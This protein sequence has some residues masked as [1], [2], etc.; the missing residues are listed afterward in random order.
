MLNLLLRNYYE[1]SKGKLINHVQQ[2][3]GDVCKLRYKIKISEHIGCWAKNPGL[4]FSLKR[5]V[6]YKHFS[7]KSTRKIKNLSNLIKV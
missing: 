3:A 4:K 7:H 5:D 2:H 6:F 1:Y